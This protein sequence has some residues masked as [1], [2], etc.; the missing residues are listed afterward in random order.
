MC[1]PQQRRHF[2]YFIDINSN[3]IIFQDKHV[4]RWF[5]GVIRDDNPRGRK[6]L[7]VYERDDLW[8]TTHLKKNKGEFIST[9]L[10]EM[11]VQ[12]YDL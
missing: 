7:V 1:L 3:R 4:N 11:Y 5:I 9:D 6:Y 2:D 10:W 8:Y 12:Q